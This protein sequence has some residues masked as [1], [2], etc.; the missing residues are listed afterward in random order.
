MA[1]SEFISET[2]LRLAALEW[3]TLTDPQFSNV[4][5]IQAERRKRDLRSTS[6]ARIGARRSD[7]SQEERQLLVAI[8][9]SQRQQMTW[10]S[11]T[12]PEAA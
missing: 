5:S 12:P 8:D 6:E 1:L 4:T 7:R 9:R 3:L 10:T 11:R 2:E